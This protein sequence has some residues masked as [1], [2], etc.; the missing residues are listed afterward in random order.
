[1]LE[2]APIFLELAL[3]PRATCG[4]AKRS[5]AEAKTSQRAQMDDRPK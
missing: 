4:A 1:V 2:L 3:K 5:V